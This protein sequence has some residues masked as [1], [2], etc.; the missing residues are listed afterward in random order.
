MYSAVYDGVANGYDF[1]TTNIN[2]TLGIRFK[3]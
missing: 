3:F 2:P 1:N